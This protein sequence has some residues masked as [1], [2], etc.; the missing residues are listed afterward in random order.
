MIKLNLLYKYLVVLFC[1]ALLASELSAQ[2]ENTVYINEFLASNKKNLL[3]EDGESSD[4]IEIYNPTKETMD[5]SDWALT[6]DSLN[7]QKWIFPNVE[8]ASGDFLVVFA[9]LKDRRAPGQELHTNFR[10]ESSGEYLALINKSGEV[11]SEFKPEFGKQYEDISYGVLQNKDTLK[12]VNESTK[13]KVIIPTQEEWNGIRLTWSGSGEQIDDSGWKDAYPAVGYDIRN[14]VSNINL[15]LGKPVIQS[16]EYNGGNFPASLAT[17]GNSNNFTHTGDSDFSPWLEVD[18]EKTY[19]V[20]RVIIQNRKNCCQERLYNITIEVLDE[21]GNSLYESPTINSFDEGETPV[22]PGSQIEYTFDDLPAGGIGGQKIRIKKVSVS[23]VREYLSIAELEVFGI[24]SYNNEILTD[25]EEM[26]GSG[27]VALMRFPFRIENISEIDHVQLQMKYDDG[28]V[29]FVNGVEMAS[30]NKPETNLSYNSVASQTHFAKS[31]EVFN[32]P[33]SALREGE[34]VLAIAGLNNSKDDN[35]FFINSNLFA[36]KIEAAGYGFFVVPTPGSLNSEGVEG[37]VADTKFDIDRGFF[38][39]AFAVT[40]S[41]ETP[42]ATIIYTTDGSEPT[43]TNGTKVNPATEETIPIARIDI[44]K[45]TILRAAAF[46][47]GLQSTNTDTHSYIFLDDIITS[48]VMDKTI[49]NDGRYKPYMKQ[50]L[51]GLPTLSLVIPPGTIEDE[52]DRKASLEWIVPGSE[53]GFQVNC[54]AR[55][56]GGEWAGPFAKQNFRVYFRSRYGVSKLKYPL[57]EGFEFGIP[58][59]DKFDQLEIRAGSHDMVQRGFYMSNRFADDSMLEMGNL[60]S[61]GRFVHLYFNGVY[62]GM[63]HLRERFNADWLSQYAGGDKEDYEAISGNKNIGGWTLNDRV[64][65]G[66]GTAWETAKSLRED[67]QSIKEYVDLQSYIDFMLLYMFGNSENEYRC[68]GSTIPGVGFQF[69]LNDADGFLRDTGNRTNMGQPGQQ[70]ADGPGSIFSMLF[71]E[72]HPAYKTLLADRIHKHFF[73]NGALTS[74]SIADRLGKRCN[75]VTI[76]F[77]AEAA[78]WGYRSPDSWEGAKND[79]F[80]NVIPYRPATVLQQFIDAGF[81]PDL[82]APIFLLNS[83]EKYG[84]NFIAGDQLDLQASSG[85]IYYT[86]DGSDPYNPVK[87]DNEAEVLIESA[88]NKKVLILSNAIPDN[89][90]KLNFDDSGWTE[91]TGG[92]GYEKDAGYEP[93]IGIDVSSMHN[94]YHGCLIRIPFTVDESVKSSID[95]LVLKMKYD[96]GFVAY[97]NGEEVARANVSDNQVW[98]SNASGLNEANSA[99][100]LNISAFIDKLKNG[101]N[102]LAIH[103]LNASVGSSDF[104][105]SAEL[106]ASTISDFEEQLTPNAILYDNLGVILDT[107]V[108]V[109]A[110]TFKDGIWSALS[111]ATFTKSIATDIKEDEVLGSKQFEVFCFPNPFSNQILFRTSVLKSN[112][113]KLEIFNI[114][115]SRMHVQEYLVTAGQRTSIRVKTEGWEQGIYMYRI[116]NEK[117]EYKAGKIIKTN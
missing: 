57:F 30:S 87:D 65:D 91:G 1:T 47:N 41:S 52:I 110:R 101:D 16:S 114:S 103:G 4:W 20:D 34:N 93:E 72:G 95:K 22:S 77:Y 104:L 60:N 28:F 63:Y 71:K 36:F 85:N 6:D 58:T 108:V 88:A 117:G 46:R 11:V 96:D 94:K 81:Y 33:V 5:L 73:N 78:R 10:L 109:T 68:V 40:V 76:P 102:L 2:A 43:L 106:E 48:E 112:S 14:A 82:E 80:S 64:Y 7:L 19:F 9:S 67:Y 24:E 89:W 59:A 35:S 3:D 13:G 50:A 42:G 75:E 39:E 17:D 44:N 62:W 70:H 18:L 98:D 74:N 25:I 105:I 31:V 51:S 86:L 23:G 27:S 99:K 32:V 116:K 113:V 107:T 100:N 15:A 26:N 61:H 37:F 45:T 8:I 69:Q 90:N 84:G 79:Y 66:E 55:Y 111:Q 83:E 29:A 115:G 54:G 56:Y 97:L 38:E 49:T 12:L 53:E 92:V 21:N